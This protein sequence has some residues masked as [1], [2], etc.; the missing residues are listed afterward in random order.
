MTSI[1][2]PVNA[3]SSKWI[4]IEN[5][6]GQGFKIAQVPGSGGIGD[7]A[8]PLFK[9]LTYLPLKQAQEMVDR[10]LAMREVSVPAAAVTVPAQKNKPSL[11]DRVKNAVQ[12]AL[13]PNDSSNSMR[14][15]PAASSNPQEAGIA[16]DVATDSDSARSVNSAS[17][18]PREQVLNGLEAN[19]SIQ[20][21]ESIADGE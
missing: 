1:N 9:S 18:T 5:E 11:F 20:S 15:S 8:L 21:D 4:A 19:H 7:I 3:V 6:N 12:S 14:S 2:N 17:S 10:M 13:C 16:S